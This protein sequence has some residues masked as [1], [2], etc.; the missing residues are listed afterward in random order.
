MRAEI[1]EDFGIHLCNFPFLME[2]ATLEFVQTVSTTYRHVVITYLRAQRLQVLRL[3][4]QQRAAIF[5]DHL[6]VLKFL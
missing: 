4:H 2:I 6:L 1:A 5:L 3:P